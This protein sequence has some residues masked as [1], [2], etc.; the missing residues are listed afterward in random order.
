MTGCPLEAP[1]AAMPQRSFHTLPRYWPV[2][3]TAEHLETAN[4]RVRIGLDAP[5]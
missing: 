5:A 2:E 3:R 1:I 4:Y